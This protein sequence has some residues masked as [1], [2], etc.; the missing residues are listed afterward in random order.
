L[1]VNVLSSP[2]NAKTVDIKRPLIFTDA[3]GDTVRMTVKGPGSA[4]VILRGDAVDNTDIEFID[5][6]DSTNKTNITVAV[7]RRGGGDGLISIGSFD[8]SGA[9]VKNIKIKGDVG[10]LEVGAGVPGGVAINML[11]VNSLG[12]ARPVGSRA[13]STINGSVKVLN[14]AKDIEGVLTVTGGR[15]DETGLG[16]TAANVVN[17]VVIGRNIDGSD[18]GQAAGLLLVRG[19]LG[20]LTVKGSVIGGA[21]RSGIV[22]GGTIKKLS[23]AGSVTSPDI[24]HP[25]TISALGIVGAPSAKGAIAL[26]SLKVGGDVLNAEI[27][28]GFRINGVAAN[29][30][31]GIGKVVINGKWT[32]S[33]IAA[34]VADST[35]DGY[36]RND[37]LIAGGSSTILS[38]IA[39]ITIAGAVAGSDAA[40]QH[41]GITAEQVGQL[42]VGKARQPLVAGSADA[43]DLAQGFKLIDFA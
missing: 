32:S 18:G 7:K 34:G 21:D 12:V 6:T 20:S 10:R 13:D 29:A 14:I 15:P 19:D 38:R 40:G 35:G 43:L 11:T 28:A 31:A 25:V 9:D 16:G 17:K 5:I 3:D 36:G 42:K 23:V 33:S 1:D 30:D 37:T 24:D 27:L 4:R 41:F 2:V 22:V 26:K 8:A 39:S